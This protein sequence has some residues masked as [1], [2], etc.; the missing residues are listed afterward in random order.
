MVEI[1]SILPDQL[2]LVADEPGNANKSNGEY[3]WRFDE[4]GSGEKR[5]VRVSYRIK[6]GTAYGTALAL[7]N[8]LKYQD[9]LGNSY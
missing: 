9:Q 7:K 4:L 5:T 6:S 2:E 1:R 3:S 8:D